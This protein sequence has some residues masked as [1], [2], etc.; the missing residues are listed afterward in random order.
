MSPQLQIQVIQIKSVKFFTHIS[1][2]KK[3]LEIIKQIH[4]SM[5][6]L[7][8]AFCFDTVKLSS[9]PLSF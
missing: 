5:T 1:K 2:K 7:G 8:S 6:S 9:Y 4:F 3:S